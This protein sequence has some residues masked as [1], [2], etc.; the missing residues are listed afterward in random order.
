[1]AEETGEPTASVERDGCHGPRGDAAVAPASLSPAIPA[2][3]SPST[4]MGTVSFRIATTRRVAAV[5]APSRLTSLEEREERVERRRGARAG[6]G[7]ASSSEEVDAAL[8]SART[9]AGAGDGAATEG[10]AAGAS[11]AKL[12]GAGGGGGGCG[13][14]I[15]A[16][17]SST[18]GV[19]ALPVSEAGAVAVA[20][21]LVPAGG[22]RGAAGAAAADA[23]TATAAALVPGPGKRTVR[24]VTTVGEAF[25][26]L[27]KKL[28]ASDVRDDAAMAAADA[29][30]EATEAAS[31]PVAD[32]ASPPAAAADVLTAPSLAECDADAGRT[33]RRSEM[34]FSSPPL[35]LLRLLTGRTCEP[36]T[37]RTAA[38]AAA[39]VEALAAAVVVAAAAAIASCSP[40]GRAERLGDLA[41]RDVAADDVDSSSELDEPTRGRGFD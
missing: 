17:P 22:G 31:L 32:T 33:T 37:G 8:S 13:D 7:A 29:L 9:A 28:D 24:S 30:G 11:A 3:V 38:A 26:A 2:P 15:A 19:G 14:G 10:G 34:L 41:D 21:A 25:L 40:A 16:A 5:T 35:L 39:A 1:M 6:A 23:G 12:H 4:L 36:A 20:D 27:K 18:E